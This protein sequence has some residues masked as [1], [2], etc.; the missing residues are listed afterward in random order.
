MQL[1]SQ[2]TCQVHLHIEKVLATLGGEILSLT[3]EKPYIKQP[4]L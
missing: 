2:I 3:N 1:A 4:Q